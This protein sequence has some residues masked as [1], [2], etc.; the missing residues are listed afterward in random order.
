MHVHVSHPDGEATFW[1]APE[2]ELVK[3][4]RDAMI[5]QICSVERPTDDHLY[6]KQ[7]DIDLS[8]QSIR[9]RLRADSC[10]PVSIRA[11]HFRFSILF[12]SGYL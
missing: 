11:R 2:V 4:F 10:A 3:W 1:L 8:V 12:A 7:L 9:A 5:A 6:W